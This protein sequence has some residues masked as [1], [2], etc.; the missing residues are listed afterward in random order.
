[1]TAPSRRRFL[2]AAAATLGLSGCLDSRDAGTGE[3]LTDPP[4]T[5]RPVTSTGSATP[6]SAPTATDAPETA[7]EPPTD[8][9]AD[10]AT[11]TSTADGTALA[12]RQTFDQSVTTPVIGD[13]LVF[14]GSG[15]GAVRAYTLDGEPAWKRSFAPAIYDLTVADGCL[16]VRSGS[17]DLPGEHTVHALDAASG[18]ERWTFS[19]RTWWLE[20]L[21]AADGTA[22]V[23]TAD[24]ALEDTGETLYALALDSGDTEWSAE[25]GD[26]REAILTDDAIVVSSTRRMYVFDRDDG[27]ERW[28][29]A[30]EELYTTLAAVD[31]T[32]VYAQRSESSDAYSELLCLDPATGE[33]RWRFDSWAVTSTAAGDGDLFVGGAH[34]GALDT[35]DGS[36]RWEV[37]RPG[38]LTDA[39]LT[40]DRLYT[41][42]DRVTAI[43]RE[44]EQAWTWT[45]DPPQDGVSAAGVANGTL[46]LDSYHDAEVRKEYKF[47]IDAASGDGRWRFENGT[48]LSDLAVGSDLAVAGGEDGSL[49][50]LR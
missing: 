26:P 5:G 18:R 50:A 23:A 49:Y 29:R 27:D 25:I 35:A 9:P 33:E 32:V 20:V 31:G 39:S 40:A 13:G 41:G 10:T 30:G 28:N 21:A 3:S 36:V 37:D 4:T 16:L 1:M 17:N 24:D 8:S 43:S 12:W 44:G 15:S 14:A 48:S 6:T 38:M 22:Y 45:P 11:E 46:Y 2:A 47:A 42:I 34:T 7:T 19:P